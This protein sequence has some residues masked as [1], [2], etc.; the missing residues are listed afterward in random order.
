MKNYF[1]YFCIA[2]V[3]LQVLSCQ[4]DTPSA[5][6]EGVEK[7]EEKTPPPPSTLP[8]TL[9]S[10]DDLST[11]KTKGKNW[12]VVGAVEADMDQKHHINLSAGTGVLVNN[13]SET[14]KANLFSSFEHGDME[15][16]LEFMMP[17]GSNSGIYFQSRYEIQL[18]DSYG[19]EEMRVSDCGAIYQRWDESR[20]KGKKGYEGHPPKANASKAPGLW[21]TLKIFFRA[22]QFDKAG[23]KTKNA[24]FEHV[25]LNGFLLHENVELKGTTRG[26][27]A[28]ID[29]E[30]PYAPFMIQGDHGPVA[31]RNIRYKAYNRDS[32]SVSNVKYKL[33]ELP[34]SHRGM[35][36]NWDQ[37]KLVDQGT[38]D[39]LDITNLNGELEDF[40][41]MQFEADLR[42]DI[43]GAYLLNV[44]ARN[45][46][47][48]FINDTLVV[49]PKGKDFG[50][51]LVNLTKGTHKLRI[52]FFH[53]KW[54][55]WMFVG[56]EGPGIEKQNFPNKVPPRPWDREP[57]VKLLLVKDEPEILRSFIQHGEKKRTHCISVGETSG[58]N[59]SCDLSEG[60]ILRLWKGDF[61]DVTNMWYQRGEP[62]TSEPLN[63]FIEG[64][65]G[66]AVAQL[67]HPDSA[68]TSSE[69]SAFEYK[70]YQ[71]DKAGKP[72]FK[73]Q[74]EDAR[75]EDQLKAAKNNKGITRSFSIKNNHLDDL[76]LR[77]AQADHIKKIP[78][79]YYSIGGSYYMNLA[80][81]MPEPL[82]RTIDG[83]QELLLPVQGDKTIEYDFI[84]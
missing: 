71:I 30:V 4:T 9:I 21:Q 29:D 60:S 50:F 34:E 53:L 32:L 40:F 52:D 59:Y 65:T 17:K 6:I 15:L 74:F 13:Q 37:L 61:L 47:N 72:I 77:V 54:R 81:T 16:E 11:F 69:A 83:K 20:P 56:Y 23:N 3:L 70:G 64:T 25:Y 62:Q 33:Y 2:I 48:L 36:T 67:S 24:S 63:A 19:V 44:V 28:K 51:G 41:A 27:A 43:P 7:T 35:P 55:H 5:P 42:V 58:W 39:L 45:S 82:L 18:Y 22:P 49:N 68:W 84:W 57:D 73:Y 12:Q 8:H 10:L 14:E 1:T 76:Y 46:A 80:K 78:N 38:S 31:F 66:V 75:I 79:G 26:A